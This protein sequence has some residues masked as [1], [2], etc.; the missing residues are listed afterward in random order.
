MQ[1]MT[2]QSYASDAV[3]KHGIA[4]VQAISPGW[5]ALGARDVLMSLAPYYQC[6][7]EDTEARFYS[8]A[9]QLAYLVGCGWM[10]YPWFD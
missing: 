5:G 3:D 9:G 4:E 1:W 6:D 7:N 2:L 8:G 10:L